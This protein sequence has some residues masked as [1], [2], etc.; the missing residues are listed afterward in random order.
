MK[1]CYSLSAM[2]KGILSLLY[3]PIPSLYIDREEPI[4]DIY[5]YLGTLTLYI[6]CLLLL[7]DY[8]IL[9]TDNIYTYRAIQNI[10]AF[11]ASPPQSRLYI[12]NT[13]QGWLPFIIIGGGMHILGHLFRNDTMKEKKTYSKNEIKKMIMESY[14]YWYKKT[15][16]ASIK[17]NIP[18]QPRLNNYYRKNIR[19][20]I[21]KDMKKKGIHPD[22]VEKHLNTIL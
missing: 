8:F 22:I 19:K 13:N 5:Y 14:D 7:Y 15:Y 16:W 1:K 10:P 4:W 3:T 20:H 11:I 9:N 12:C 18:V 21:H 17:Y 6:G 2:P